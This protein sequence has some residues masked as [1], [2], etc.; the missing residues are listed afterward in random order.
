MPCY[1]MN[2]VTVE[3][4]VKHLSILENAAKALGWSWSQAGN[5]V[6]AGT[7]RINMESGTARV[8]S[9]N[10]DS[11]NRLKQ[12]YSRQA[13][14]KAAKMMKKTKWFVKEINRQKLEL[15]AY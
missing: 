4:K 1:Q 8:D 7:V 15:R 3:F 14:M 10:R 12:E 2:L 9:Y 5:T 13:V 6:V 11:V